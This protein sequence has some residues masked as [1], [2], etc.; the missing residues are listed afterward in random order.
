MR[1]ITKGKYGQFLLLPAT[2]PHI[3]PQFFFQWSFWLILDLCKQK[4]TYFD[5]QS[6]TTT[7]FKRNCMYSLKEVKCSPSPLF[8]QVPPKTAVT[9]LS[10]PNVITV[11]ITVFIMVRAHSIQTTM[12]NLIVLVKFGM[13]KF[14]AWITHNYLLFS[15]FKCTLLNILKSH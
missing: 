12:D 2:T 6:K 13:L 3:N 11:T 15:P 8:C 1:S 7:I 10:T 5:K 9:F 4:G 14:G